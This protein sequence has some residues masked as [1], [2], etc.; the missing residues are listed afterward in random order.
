MKSTYAGYCTVKERSACNNYWALGVTDI[1]T[2][3]ALVSTRAECAN[4]GGF[5]NYVA[6]N[7]QCDCCYD[8][9]DATTDMGDHYSVD[10]LKLLW[11]AEERCEDIETPVSVYCP[12][13][14]H[15]HEDGEGCYNEMVAI[16]AGYV[17]P[18]GLMLDLEAM[19][20]VRDAGFLIACPPGFEPTPDGLRCSD[21]QAVGG[22]V[23][24]PQGWILSDDGWTCFMVTFD[25]EADPE[26][27]CLIREQ[28]YCS[29]YEQIGYA[30]NQ[31]ACATMAQMEF[32]KCAT[33]GGFFTF[34]FLD[35][36]CDCCLS[37]AYVFEDMAYG[38]Y[39]SLFKHKAS[40]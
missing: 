25:S 39:E 1:D 13:G 38:E 24:C 28:Y 23:Q 37:E 22:Y 12:P 11:T 10:F 18:P 26:N 16:T 8:E 29:Q 34:S 36:H 15:S 2:C 21:P 35:N 40:T 19:A 33:S 6:E 9:A 5:F 7:G 32:S 14:W 3:A 20:C 17:C 27:V 31:F 4:G 30:T